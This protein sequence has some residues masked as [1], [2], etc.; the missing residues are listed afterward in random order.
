MMVAFQACDSPASVPVIGDA[1]RLGRLQQ[2]SLGR[3]GRFDQEPTVA[4]CPLGAGVH[5]CP[6]QAE[7]T[8][9]FPR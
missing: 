2:G 4:I 6:Q 7:D 3:F 5:S 9:F 1:C 8:A